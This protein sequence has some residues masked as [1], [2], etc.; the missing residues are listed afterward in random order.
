MTNPD[1][2]DAGASH[3]LSGALRLALCVTVD[4][5]VQRRKWPFLELTSLHVS[6]G[7]KAEYYIL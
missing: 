2:F 3:I 7:H 1:L 6:P 4:K 5:I